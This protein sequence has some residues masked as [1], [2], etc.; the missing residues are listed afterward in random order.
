MGTLRHSLTM[1][2]DHNRAHLEQH[3]ASIRNELDKVNRA[4][5]MTGG[6]RYQQT[7]NGSFSAVSTP[8]FVSKY[9]CENS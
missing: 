5:L 6:G 7:L 9:L 3:I 1:H 2:M 4:V 8:I